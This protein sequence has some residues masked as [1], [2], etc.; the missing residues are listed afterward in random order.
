MKHNDRK[1]LHSQTLAQLQT[2]LQELKLDLAKAE[3]QKRIGKLTNP[4]IVSTLRD[5]VA[6]VLTI[7]KHQQL[8]TMSDLKS[9]R[10]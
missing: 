2:K 3:T 7:I 1:A 8:T 4:R 10:N 9:D 5:D 6:R